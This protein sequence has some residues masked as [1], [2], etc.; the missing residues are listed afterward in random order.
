MHTGQRTS[1]HSLMSLANSTESVWIREEEVDGKGD[2][3]DRRSKDRDRDLLSLGIL[4]GRIEQNHQ[5]LP[6]LYDEDLS[7]KTIH[8][9]VTKQGCKRLRSVNK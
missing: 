4:T 3:R 9:T 5:N 2:A 7:S 6:A 1:S 8:G